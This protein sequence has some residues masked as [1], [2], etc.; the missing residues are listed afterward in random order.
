MSM[1]MHWGVVVALTFVT[2]CHARNMEAH[3]PTLDKLRWSALLLGS[4]ASL[5]Q[6]GL[7]AWTMGA[8]VLVFVVLPSSVREF[9]MPTELHPDALH[10]VW[11]RGRE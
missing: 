5:P 8:G 2:L 6:F 3:H 11:G 10:E 9:F 1:L 4:V 7:G